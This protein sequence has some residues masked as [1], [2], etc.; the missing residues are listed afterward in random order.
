MD[1]NGCFTTLVPGNSAFRPETLVL[2]LL[3]AEA[4][5]N[6]LKHHFGSNK[7]DWRLHNFGTPKIVHLGPSRQDFHRLTCRRLAKCYETLPNI[8]LSPMEQIGCFTT[9]VP[10]N[11]AFSPN[12]QVFHLFTWRR[13]VKCSKTLPRIIWV[14]WTRMDVSQLWYH[15]VVHS[16][17]NTS[18]ATFT[19]R[20]I[21]IYF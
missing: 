9:S 12:T 13:L 17:S 1:K 3:C 8:I 7:V 4:L 10:R 14:Q 6:T 19:C 11:S 5:Q 18:F 20:R 16:G 21:A 15:E 2:H